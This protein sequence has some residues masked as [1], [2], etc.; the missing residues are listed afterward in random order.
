MSDE[1]NTYCVLAL[2]DKTD[3]ENLERI[4]AAKSEF[5]TSVIIRFLNK[6]D[7]VAP[8]EGEDWYL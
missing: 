8:I 4:F 3:K 7:S 5:D 2:I 6:P 1:D